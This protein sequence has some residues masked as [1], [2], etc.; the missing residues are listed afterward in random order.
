MSYRIESQ[1]ENLC[2]QPIELLKKCQSL[3]YASLT[4]IQKTYA[5]KS[6]IDILCK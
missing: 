6:L 5:I 2:R 3:S 4:S 1:G